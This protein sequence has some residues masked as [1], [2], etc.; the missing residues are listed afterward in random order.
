MDLFQR[1]SRVT[2]QLTDRTQ[3]SLRQRMELAWEFLS[4]GDFFNAIQEFQRL[5]QEHATYAPAWYGLGRAQWLSLQAHAS[6][7]SESAQHLGAQAHQS[8]QQAIALAPNYAEAWH[9]LGQLYEHQQR[10]ADALLAYQTAW[11]NNPT[12]DLRT[13]LARHLG[14]IYAALQKPPQAIRWFRQALSYQPQDASLWHHLAYTWEAMGEPV[15]ART[16]WTKATQIAPNDVIAWYHLGRL[17]ESAHQWTDSLTAYHAALTQQAVP[18][19]L[20]AMARIALQQQQ[21]QQALDYLQQAMQVQNLETGFFDSREL[22]PPERWEVLG[23]QAK[24]YEAEGQLDKTLEV[25]QQFEG[26]PDSNLL[27]QRLFFAVQHG[28]LPAA[29]VWSQDPRLAEQ[30]AAHMIQSLNP[31]LSFEQA[32]TLLQPHL[33]GVFSYHLSDKVKTFGHPEGISAI[34]RLALW[35]VVHIAWKHKQSHLF[36]KALQWLWISAPSDDLPLQKLY[37]TLKPA[38]SPNTSFWQWLSSAQDVLQRLP[39]GKPWQQQCQEDQQEQQAPLRVVVL[40]EFNAGKSTLLNAWVEEDL[41]PTGITPTTALVTVLR[42]GTEATC[43][44]RFRDGTSLALS[45]Q[46][47]TELLQTLS[48]REAM[49]IDCVE[50]TLPHPHLQGMELVDTPGLNAWSTWHEDITR[51]WFTRADV[52]LWLLSAD[53]AGKA[54]ERQAI[55]AL[56]EAHPALV[57]GVLTKADRF[58]TEESPLSSQIDPADRVIQSLLLHLQDPQQ[59][60]GTLFQRILPISGREARMGQKNSEPALVNRSQVPLLKAWILTEWVPNTLGLKEKR[61]RAQASTWLAQAIHHA[62]KFAPAS[63]SEWPPFSPPEEANRLVGLARKAWLMDMGH[64]YEQVARDLLDLPLPQRNFLQDVAF[65]S[66][67]RDFLAQQ[68]RTVWKELCLRSCQF[69]EEQ[70][71]QRLT[72]LASFLHPLPTNLLRQLLPV[73]EFVSFLEGALAGG[74]LDH[75]CQRV[76]PSTERTEFAFARALERTLPTSLENIQQRWL[77]PIHAIVKQQLFILAQNARA[78]HA[79]QTWPY[80]LHQAMLSQPLQEL[81]QILSSKF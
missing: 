65:S 38:V 17:F 35:C 34:Q 66:T 27:L 67:D 13:L 9:Q 1:F 64:A 73:N 44:V 80:H 59:G 81:Q 46:R 63:P 8:L 4:H 19:V 55:A 57:V 41:L 71:H 26:C 2:S 18:T 29:L 50:L 70:L 11:K 32:W 14:H 76:F 62:T 20:V 53:Q 79:E 40:G 75:L 24:A 42:Y 51:S 72:P 47:R 68:L 31:R 6:P 56:Q 10:F 22:P 49:R 74:L 5:T 16:A 37:S 12:S 21:P 3:E 45:W 7:S 77:D 43:R 28:F 69:L 30:P 52:V 36:G 25:Y 58:R 61:L 60:L 15:E 39:E 23:L 33:P 48:E 54:S 78:H